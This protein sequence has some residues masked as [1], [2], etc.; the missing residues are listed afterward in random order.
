MIFH[1]GCSSSTDRSLLYEVPIEQDMFTCISNF[2]FQTKVQFSVRPLDHS[3]D[4]YL[5]QLP[6]APK[7]LYNLWIQLFVLLIPSIKKRL[8]VLQ[9]PW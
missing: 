5:K 4:P 2:S 6:L 9:P 7:V 8:I 1:A 3:E